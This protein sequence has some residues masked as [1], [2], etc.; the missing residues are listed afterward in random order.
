MMPLDLS[1]V[2]VNH[3]HG[4]LA[5]SCFESLYALPDRVRFE[6]ILIDNACTDGAARRIANRFPEVRIHRNARP[7]GFAANANTGMRALGCGRY[8]LLLNPDVVCIPGML[9]QLV[10]FMDT[11]PEAGIAAPRL[12]NPDGSPQPNCRHFPTPGT[13][14]M[15]VLRLN[16]SPLVRRYLMSDR[17][18]VAASEADWV[19]G[20]VL[21]ARRAAV[22]RVGLLDERY[23]L[24]WEDMDWCY[25]MRHD[26]WKV[27][28]VPE[29]R[30]VHALQRE[31][32]RRPFSRAGRQQL[33]GAMKFFHKFGWNAGAQKDA[34]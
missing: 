20:A 15:R 24:Y 23:F 6:M 30:A 3:N 27:Y 18:H 31:G 7:R 5:E 26:G 11:H 8:L 1:I 34:A 22:E 32:A 10:L 19:T 14:A 2:V 28:Y 21:M 29:A 13:L 25:R 12:L 16:A 4:P 17:P 33:L 9:H